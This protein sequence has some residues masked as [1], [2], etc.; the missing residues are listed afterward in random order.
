MSFVAIKLDEFSNKLTLSELKNYIPKWDII[1]DHVFLY[2]GIA[3]RNEIIGKKYDI[4]VTHFGYS[5]GTI[6]IKT[7]IDGINDN[8]TIVVAVNSKGRY[9]EDDAKNIT[10]WI[11]L[12]KKFVLKG[13]VAQY[14]NNKKIHES[15]SISNKMKTQ[16]LRVAFYDF[17]STL[18][19]VPNAEFGKFYWEK[20]KGKKYPHIGWWSKKESLDT[21]VFKFN[22]IEEVVKRL[23]RDF[24]DESCWTVLLTNRIDKLKEEVNK[25]LQNNGVSLDQFKMSRPGSPSKLLRIKE[26]LNDIPQSH[27][28]E[29]YDDDMGN[30]KLF[31]QLKSELEENGKSV[32]IYHINPKN[33]I[34]RLTKI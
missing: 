2:D 15:E 25:I 4:V 5:N 17:D 30:I 16:I 28:I 23:K 31:E 32:T 22:P 13:I 12:K 19:E 27:L 21:D 26:V 9:T 8:K 6:A 20:K 3:K 14:E 34:P 24:E 33:Y 18:V 11:E 7:K 10:Y 29:I 1:I